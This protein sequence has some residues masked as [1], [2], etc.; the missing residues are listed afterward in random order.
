MAEEVIHKNFTSGRLV[1]LQVVI[2]VHTKDDWLP[3]K[4]FLIRSFLKTSQ[5]NKSIE[6]ETLSRKGLPIAKEDRGSK[7][8]HV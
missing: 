4:F 5:N 8:E 2:S 3:S 7:Q 6:K 1:H